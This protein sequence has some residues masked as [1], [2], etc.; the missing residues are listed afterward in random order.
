MRRNEHAHGDKKRDI[1]LSKTPYQLPPPPPPPPPP[2]NPP[3]EENPD[4]L[5]DGGVDEADKVEA[6]DE[7]KLLLIATELKYEPA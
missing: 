2:E 1:E 6:N 7:L 3:P 5:V 4:E